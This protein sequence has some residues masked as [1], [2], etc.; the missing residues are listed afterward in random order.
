MKWGFKW[1]HAKRKFTCSIKS[2]VNQKVSWSLHDNDLQPLPLDENLENSI[3]ERVASKAAVRKLTKSQLEDALKR[4]KLD[5][6]QAKK[7]LNVAKKLAD[8]QEKYVVAWDGRDWQKNMSPDMMPTF[9]TKDS[10]TG[11]LLYHSS[12]HTC[13]VGYKNTACKMPTQCFRL[14]LV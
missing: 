8:D 5:A 14:C 1:K 6:D 7:E 4:A 3:L 11:T 2:G 12:Y 9:P 10:K 13:E